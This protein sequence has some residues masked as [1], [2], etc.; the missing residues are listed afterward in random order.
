M[1]PFARTPLAGLTVHAVTAFADNYLWLLQAQQRAIAIDPGDADA[2]HDAL[3]ALGLTLDAIFITHHHRDHIG[4]LQALAARW[5]CPVFG[6]DDSRIEG[7]DRPCRDGDR[8]ARDGFPEFEVWQ[9][10]GH[11]RTHLAYRLDDAIFV[12]DTLFGGGCGRIFEGDAAQLHASLQRIAALPGTTL[13]FCSHEYTRANLA[14]AAVVEPGNA[15]VAERVRRLDPQRPSVPF[16]LAG[17][18]DSNVFLRC[19]KPP[20][21]AAAEAHFGASFADTGA[22]FAAVRRWKDSHV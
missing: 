6:P 9:V 15:A 11:T 17:E 1:P 8:I 4:G 20:V 16:A 13:V 2:V 21:R 5:R 22:V 12:G 19:G 3:Q 7:I 14:F 10:P 18:L